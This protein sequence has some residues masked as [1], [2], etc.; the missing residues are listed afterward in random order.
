MT[1]TKPGD[2]RENMHRPA[3]SRRGLLLGG[4]AAAVG[5]A[6][7]FAAAG[8][9]DG[10]KAVEPQALPNG[11]DTVAF[12]G[13]RQPGI[14][15]L[16]PAFVTFLAMDLETDSAD[17]RAEQRDLLRRILGIISKDA[18]RLMAG[19]GILADT[20]PELAENPARLTLTVGLGAGPVR[21]V[22]KSLVPDWLKDLPAFPIDKL[23]K[24]WGQS[25][26]LV[27]FCGDDRVSLLH[28]RRSIQK[29]LRTLAKTVWIQDGFRHSRG[30]MAEGATMR[31]LFGQL[32]GSGNPRDEM[33]ERA[34][35]GGENLEPWIAG[36]TSL[37]LRRIE[38]D[39]DT[40]DAVDRPARDF[41]LGRRQD[42]GAPLTGHHEFDT[43]DLRVRDD[44]GFPVI[45]ADSH[46]ARGQAREADE[47]ILRRG[48]NYLEGE[49][50]GL[51][52]ASYQCDVQRQFL[53]I[54]KR[55]AERDMLNEW[56][57]PVGSAV[58]A[59]LPG[60]AEGSFLGQEMFDA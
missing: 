33:A 52:F 6:A 23:E 60:C 5:A 57:T 48:Y 38:M 16:A 8:L 35:W 18:A 25:D 47:H 10:A 9:P 59:I 32:D 14:T 26:L 20:D 34:V 15:T 30:S 54:Q 12:H 17:G 41:S 2:P 1:D 13:H 56:T 3:P 11:G 53:P 4:A 31:N 19:R 58:Y 22:N 39:L 50:A 28:A 44:S 36:G 7:G 51:L 46:V 24:A 29:D 21:I 55:M 27:Q 40:W 45:S 42:T 49:K 43:P 37:V